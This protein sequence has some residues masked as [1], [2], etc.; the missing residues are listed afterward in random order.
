M[1]WPWEKPT[2]ESKDVKDEELT[3]HGNEDMSDEEILEQLHRL[4]KSRVET[5]VEMEAR[6]PPSLDAEPFDAPRAQTAIVEALQ[7]SVKQYGA[8]LALESGAAAGEETRL[9]G[10]EI[11]TDRVGKLAV[12]SEWINAG[13]AA[14]V[15]ADETLMK[16]VSREL[17]PDAARALKKLAGK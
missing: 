1:R 16:I 9:Y 10:E 5:P 11:I 15:V 3:R 2:T 8:H 13:R 14:E 7:A 17:T 12:A 4:K 6:R